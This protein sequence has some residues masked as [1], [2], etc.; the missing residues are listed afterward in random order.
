MSDRTDEFGRRLMFVEEIQS[1]MHQRVQRA[2]REAKITG[3][4]PSR[5]DSYAFRQDMKDLMY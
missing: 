1:D 3:R 4:K 5:E 2:M